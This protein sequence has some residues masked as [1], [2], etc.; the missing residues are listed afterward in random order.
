ML[1]HLPELDWDYLHRR[2][3]ACG[4]SQRVQQACQRLASIRERKEQRT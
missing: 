1:D 2:A 3:A 4:P